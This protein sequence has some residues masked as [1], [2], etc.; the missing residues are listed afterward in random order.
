MICLK[1]FNRHSGLFALSLCKWNGCIEENIQG[2]M[3]PESWGK[4]CGVG[5]LIAFNKAKWDPAT[6][7]VS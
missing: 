1:L 3:T 4:K 5:K 7:I 2:K 6:P